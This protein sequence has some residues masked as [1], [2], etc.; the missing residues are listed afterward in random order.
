MKYAKYFENKGYTRRYRFYSYFLISYGYQ[1]YVPP[2]THPT[3]APVP[4]QPANRND[5]NNGQ[6][7]QNMRMNAQG[8]L[9]EDEEELEHRD[10]LDYLYVFFR[11]LVLLSIVY[12]YSS[13]TRFVA[14]SLGFLFIYMWVYCALLYFC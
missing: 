6:P 4:E 14:V 3:A 5:V 9:E 7:N 13:A 11:F 2:Q 10:W 12:F 8:G 1:P